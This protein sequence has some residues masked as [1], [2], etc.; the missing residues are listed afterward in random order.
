MGD[1]S[2][3]LWLMPSDEVYH[4]LKQIIFQLSQRFSSPAFEP[5]VTLLGRLEGTETDLCSKARILARKLKP[6]LIRLGEVDYTNEYFR[7]LFV[8][9]ALSQS[10]SKA[11][12][13]S[14]ETFQAGKRS[15][16]MPH[17]SLVYADLNTAAKL[18]IIREIGTSLSD[19]FQ[20]HSMDLY[21]TTGPPETWYRIGQFELGK[22]NQ[23]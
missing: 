9:V 15:E 17:L 13:M 14:M 6:V 5:H 7:C 2:F 19:E 11:Y 18:M 20:V 3:S 10:I 21:S 12:R 22:D 16:F 8:Q 23:A 1:S 4:R